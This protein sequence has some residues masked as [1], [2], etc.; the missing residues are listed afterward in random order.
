MSKKTEK[1][2]VFLLRTF[3]PPIDDY[4]LDQLDENVKIIPGPE[5]PNPADYQILVAGR[6]SR[7]HLAASPYLKTLV[8]PWAG[9]PDETRLLLPD[10][11]QLAVHNLHH[12]AAIVAESCLAL[13]LASAKQILPYDRALRQH[14]WR[15]RYLPDS[16]M[17]LQGK[18]AL[19]L[20]YGQIGQ[21]VGVV[22]NALGMR[23]LALRRDPSKPLMPDS[24]G[25]VYGMEHLE[26]LLPQ[27]HVL[28]V[29][30]P[31]TEETEGLLGE[32]ELELLPQGAVLVN[33]GRGKVIRQ[34]A[35]YEAL[36]TGQLAG[37]GLDVWYRYPRNPDERQ[38]T[39]PADY[40]FFEL[41]NVVLSPHRAGHSAD[42][43]K[44]RSAALADLLNEAARGKPIPNPVDVESGY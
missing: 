4:F 40:P 41:D 8:I 17:L 1:I 13:L 33:V 12:N 27:A 7:E 10:F 31:L 9:L 36:R 44:M 19:I 25:N 6:P 18:T 16:S 11:P 39:N 20:G 35:L 22:L 38:G 29:T 34:D 2:N 3:D 21:R 14:D 28:I 42:T 23:V 37:A 5:L 30:L 15:K 24:P 26:E 32:H 43:E